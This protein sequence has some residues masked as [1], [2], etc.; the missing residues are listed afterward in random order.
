MMNKFH[1]QSL[2]P[3]SR[4]DKLTLIKAQVEIGFWGNIFG[5]KCIFRSECEFLFLRL[6]KAV[7]SFKFLT[8]YCIL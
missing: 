3:S 8:E 1:R 7:R 2:L 6:I 4:D 5:E